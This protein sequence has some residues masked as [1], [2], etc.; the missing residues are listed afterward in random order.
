MVRLHYYPPIFTPCSHW[1]RKGGP[2]GSNAV[3]LRTPACRDT[4]W[5]TGDVVTT[6]SH[7]HGM[8]ESGVRIPSSPPGPWSSSKTRPSQ[9]RNA[10]AHPAGSTRNSGPVVQQED[11]GFASRKHRSITGRVHQIS[12]G[13][14]SVVS[15]VDCKST[16]SGFVGAIPTPWTIPPWCNGSTTDFGSVCLGSNPSGGAI[17]NGAVA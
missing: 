2:W 17:S 12:H 11:V 8:D 3:T 15:S 4:D 5:G 9:G 6:V 16:A 1:E 14:S 7:V 10:G 13:L